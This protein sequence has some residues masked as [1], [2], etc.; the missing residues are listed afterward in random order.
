MKCG[1]FFSMLLHSNSLVFF[2][3]TGKW[4]ASQTTDPQLVYSCQTTISL[5]IKHSEDFFQKEMWF[6]CSIYCHDLLVRFAIVYD[7]CLIFFIFR[8]FRCFLEILN[9]VYS[10]IILLNIFYVP[11][12]TPCDIYPPLCNLNS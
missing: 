6:Y 11:L 2:Q 1:S 12:I 7:F 9:F 5:F 3:A 8:S 10:T 4:Q